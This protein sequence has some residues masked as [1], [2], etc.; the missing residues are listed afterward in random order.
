MLQVKYEADNYQYMTVH[1]L[2]GKYYTEAEFKEIWELYKEYERKRCY[3]TMH[4]NATATVTKA[5]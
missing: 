1:I 3:Q 5:V 2:D 4:D